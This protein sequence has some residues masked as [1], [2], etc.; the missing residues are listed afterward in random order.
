[1]EKIKEKWEEMNDIARKKC[2]NYAEKIKNKKK[3][4]GIIIRECCAV[5]Q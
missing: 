1:M 3:H 5:Y 4:F 2:E